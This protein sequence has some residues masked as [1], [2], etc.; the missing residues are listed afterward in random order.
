[1]NSTRIEFIATTSGLSISG[2]SKGYAFLENKTDLIVENLD[3]YF[4]SDERLFTAVKLAL[5]D[6]TL[7]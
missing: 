3:E 5:I 7:L 6:N 4:S 2:S 1:M